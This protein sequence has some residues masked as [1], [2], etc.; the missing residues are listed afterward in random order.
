MNILMIMSGGFLGAILRYAVSQYF[1]K[2]ELQYST[3]IVN[4][5]GSFIL[6][7][8]VGLSMSNEWYLFFSVGMLGAYT[9]FS[10]M[11]KELFELIKDRKFFIVTAYI[12]TIVILGV[13][14]TA[15]GISIGF[16]LH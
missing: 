9:T 8:C 12:T 10:T 3:F 4:V 13:G 15:I 14:S 5:S 16:W 7:V 1:N 2:H 6:G 11:S